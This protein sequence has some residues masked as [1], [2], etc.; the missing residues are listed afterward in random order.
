MSKVYNKEC[1]KGNTLILKSGYNKPTII[2]NERVDF[3]NENVWGISFEK[4][5][6]YE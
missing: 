6:L 2:N 4:S 5:V 3:A 1:E